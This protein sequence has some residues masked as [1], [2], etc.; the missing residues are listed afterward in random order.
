VKPLTLE[1]IGELFGYNMTTED[2]TDIA[3][4]VRIVRM[5]EGAHGIE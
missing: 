2:A 3:M 5:I 4:L 1:E